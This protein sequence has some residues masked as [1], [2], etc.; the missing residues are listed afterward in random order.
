MLGDGTKLDL[1]GLHKDEQTQS[2][3]C[4]GQL[5]A[6]IGHIFD[7]I[8]CYTDQGCGGKVIKIENINKGTKGIQ[9]G[10]NKGHAER[11]DSQLLA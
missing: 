4:E 9:Q 5:V 3:Q 1:L 7:G 10:I 2:K 8:F 11:D 6:G